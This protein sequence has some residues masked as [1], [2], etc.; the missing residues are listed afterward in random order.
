MKF[1]KALLL[2]SFGLSLS[3]CVSPK[4]VEDD[5]EKKTETE[6]GTETKTETKTETETKK[7]ETET[8]KEE[9]ETKKEETET[10][11]EKEVSEESTEPSLILNKTFVELDSRE[12]ISYTKAGG[13]LDGDITSVFSSS[14][15][16]SAS[17][18]LDPSSGLK[19]SDVKVVWSIDDSDKDYFTISPDGSNCDV[20]AIKKSRLSNL[21]CSIV[22]NSD[23]SVLISKSCE[24]RSVMTDVAWVDNQKAESIFSADDKIEAGYTARMFINGASSNY[25]GLDIVF[26]TKLKVGGVEKKLARVVGL[27]KS[28]GSGA[29][30]GVSSY[31]IRKLYI[32]NTVFMISQKA[33]GR[34]KPSGKVI[35]ATGGVNHI[36]F[37]GDCIYFQETI[38]GSNVTFPAFYNAVRNRGSDTLKFDFN[39]YAVVEKE[40]IPYP[41]SFTDC[42][43]FSDVFNSNTFNKR[44][45]VK[46]G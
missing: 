37:N 19:E 8:K 11:E 31:P 12:A 13:G 16:V 3:S 32:P 35:F 15:K 22:K 46:R 2:L 28:D 1:L 10:T 17:W 36:F 23:N 25:S 43:S 45:L 41:T 29:I 24:L 34:L 9:T 30:D 44:V 39:K 26:P 38:K 42:S 4:E 40:D 6:N 5:I 21:T 20:T 18:S 33:F 14:E 7:E 27:A